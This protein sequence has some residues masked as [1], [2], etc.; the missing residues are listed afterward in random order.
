MLLF[1]N[2]KIN[3]GLYITGKRPDG[4]HNLESVFLPV[5]FTDALE[6][7]EAKQFRFRTETKVDLGDPE[8]NLCVK[9]YRLLQ[10]AY[11]I[12]PVDMFLL[13]N[14]PTG[15]GLGG[16]SADGTFALL[17]L[18]QLFDLG[19]SEGTLEE[20]A[21]RLGSDCPFFIR[22]KPAYVTGR[23]TDIQVIDFP[24]TECWITLVHPGIHI[25]TKEAFA[26]IQPMPGPHLLLDS[27]RR[28]PEE[29]MRYIRND[30]EPYA[31]A[32]HPE[33]RK[34][35]EQLL[36][37][38]AFYAAMSGSGSAIYGLSKAELALPAFPQHYWVQQK[39]WA[40]A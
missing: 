30:F 33:L 16:G 28:P 12:P 37:A 35:K 13:K 6:A 21:A 29:W 39:I 38:G 34:I 4:F 1:P 18:N 32:A 2:C 15:A 5:P 26:H 22:N 20:L 23:G 27:L 25:S 3:L 9:A 40:N 19:L 14:L 24:L 36:E 8:S 11:S 31:F 10:Q 17:L 7:V